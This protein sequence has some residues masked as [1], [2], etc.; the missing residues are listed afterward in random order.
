MLI[1]KSSCRSCFFRSFAAGFWWPFDFE[2]GLAAR[3]LLQ[4]GLTLLSGSGAWTRP[5]AARMTK[6]VKAYLT[7]ASL[8]AAFVLSKFL[9]VQTFEMVTTTLSP[10]A[11]AD[12]CGGPGQPPWKSQGRLVLSSLQV[13]HG[14]DGSAA[15]SAVAFESF[16]VVCACVERQLQTL[17]RW[18]LRSP[19]SRSSHE[20]HTVWYFPRISQCH[21]RCSGNDVTPGAGS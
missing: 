16:F 18:T 2:E 15:A 12:L 19:A 5:H 10:R 11:L 7:A 21:R 17:A 4:A 14:K 13:F 20:G 8:A 1:F 3:V 9:A 6:T